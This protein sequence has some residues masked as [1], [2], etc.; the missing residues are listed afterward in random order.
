MISVPLYD[1]ISIIYTMCDG[2]VI[3]ISCAHSYIITS[4]EIA[5]PI[6]HPSGVLVDVI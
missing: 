4:K 6:I 5:Y 2:D 1:M 3:T